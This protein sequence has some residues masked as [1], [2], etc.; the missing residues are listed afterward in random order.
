MSNHSVVDCANL[1]SRSHFESYVSSLSKAF[2][3]NFSLVDT[4]KAEVCGALWGTGSPDISGIGMTI[5]YVL[6]SAIPVFLAI[7]FF[8][9]TSTISTSRPNGRML[10][11]HAT[12]TFWDNAV[13]FT[14]SIQLASIVVLSRANF[15]ISTDGMGA[16]TMEITWAISCLTMLP[17]LP[18]TMSP[19]MFREDDSDFL[20]QPVFST[21][22]VIGQK[23]RPTAKEIAEV[24]RRKERLEAR[25]RQRFFLFVMCWLLSVYPFLSRMVAAFEKSQIGSGKGAVI[26][27][28]DWGKIEEVCF[29][30]VNTI[31]TSEERAMTALSIVSW[32]SVSL[33]IIYR[34]FLS[35]VEPEKHPTVWDWLQKRKLTVAPETPRQRL[36]WIALS[37]VVPL[38]SAT[39]LWTVFRLRGLQK[40]MTRATGGKFADGQF[41]FGQ[42]V[43]VA[44]FVPVLVE[45]GY[46]VRNRNLYFIKTQQAG[47]EDR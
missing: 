28:V 18:L 15:G 22:G 5:G 21:A 4:C 12:E 33:V 37:V 23:D 8:L 35:L 11:S 41:T 30:G 32:L 7:A 16:I 17:L 44:V 42:I 19:A 36:L 24:N 9:T 1:A 40:A 43:S 26:S 14:V 13:F 46:L 6:E 2:N 39:Q 45:L 3:G 25:D 20:Q 34:I 29:H 38:L 47:S 31:Q 10:V 27:T